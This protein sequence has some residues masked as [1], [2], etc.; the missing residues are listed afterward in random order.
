VDE[1]I[2]Q[3]SSRSGI[4]QDQAQQAVDTVLDF[5]RQ[6]LP[7]PA[8][9]QLETALNSDMAA[10]VANQIGQQVGN[11]FGGDKK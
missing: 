4:S 8:M 3:V 6:R 10:N 9:A 1:L 11:L 5:I 2:K 7:A